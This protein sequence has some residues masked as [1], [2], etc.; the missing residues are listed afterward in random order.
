MPPAW[1]RT[2]T[3]DHAAAKR[4]AEVGVRAN[5]LRETVGR[6]SGGNQQRVL[7]GRSLEARP[8]VLLLND[9]T[10]GV[11]VKAKVGI[12]AGAQAGRRRHLA[13]A[14]RRRI[15]RSC[16]VS[17]TASSA[18][19]T[20][21]L[22]PIGRARISTSSAC[23]RWLRPRGGVCASVVR[24]TMRFAGKRAWLVLGICCNYDGA[25]QQ[26]SRVDPREITSSPERR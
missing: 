17:P 24:P 20:A 15:W 2:E 19:A 23:W 25:C 22:S 21:P 11:D 6:L 10:R 7:L 18:C 14:S 16:S 13:S 4:L 12:H 8:R 26:D 5:A 3:L 1:L 9:F